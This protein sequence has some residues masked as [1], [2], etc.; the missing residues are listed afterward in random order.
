MNVVNHRDV[1]ISISKRLIEKG[2]IIIALYFLYK[3]RLWFLFVVK[4]LKYCVLPVYEIKKRPLLT[5]WSKIVVSTARFYFISLR[6][7]FIPAANI[8]FLRLIP[9]FYLQ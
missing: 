5:I 6:Q 3:Y 9:G 8:A 4:A 1:V 7:P 2:D